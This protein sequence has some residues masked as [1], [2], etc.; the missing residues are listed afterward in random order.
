M[1]PLADRIDETRQQIAAIGAVT[2]HEHDDPAFRR[3]RRDPGGAG[4][5]IT[6]LAGSN[7][8][9]PRGRGNLGGAIPAAA[10]GDDDLADHIA[11]YLGNDALYRF[12]LVERRN[13][14]RDA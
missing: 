6:A 5:A 9:R 12:R 8:P 11:R 7:D 2:I 1:G 10:I 3:G 13:D 4:I 14:D